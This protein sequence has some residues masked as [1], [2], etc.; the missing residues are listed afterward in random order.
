[1]PDS[2]E[3]HAPPPDEYKHLF[4]VLGLVLIEI[5]ATENLKTAQILADVFHNVPAMM[6]RRVS[7][8]KIMAEIEQKSTRHGRSKWISGFFETAARYR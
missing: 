7:L 5:R 3:S 1:M 2:S 6:N 8:E 4:Y